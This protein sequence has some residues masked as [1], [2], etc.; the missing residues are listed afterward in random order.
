VRAQG[1]LTLDLE[2]GELDADFCHLGIQFGYTLGP[3]RPKDIALLQSCQS[4]KPFVTMAN[5]AV[6][7][8]I[9]F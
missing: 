2:E 1:G 4:F 5:A 6:G 7:Y 3:N 9:A 8:V